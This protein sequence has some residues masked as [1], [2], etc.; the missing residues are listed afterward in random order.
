MSQFYK[1]CNKPFIHY[2]CT[3]CHGVIHKSCVNTKKIK[4]I[5]LLNGNR[6]MCCVSEHTNLSIQEEKNSLL[7]ETLNELT[8]ESELKSRQ[9]EKVKRDY[10]Q[11][12]SEASLR[13]DELN[14]LIMKNE[15]TIQRLERQ[16][17]EMESI[18]ASY[19]SK[20][21][22]HNSTQTNAIGNFPENRKIIKLISKETQTTRQ[23]VTIGTM[24]IPVQE[25]SVG[26]ASTRIDC[27]RV[28]EDN[29]FN[30]VLILSDDLGR[31]VNA[32][33]GNKLNDRYKI[34]C[35][36]KPGALYEQ[37]IEDLG[38]LAKDFTIEDH[39]VIIAGKNYFASKLKFPRCKSIWEQIK[40]CPTTNISFVGVP[41]L[42]YN[43]YNIFKFNEKL[44]AF[45]SRLNS[46]LPG[47]IDYMDV[48]DISSNAVGRIKHVLTKR[49]ANS[50]LNA[51]KK[52]NNLIFVDLNN[53]TT[54]DSSEIQD[55]SPSKSLQ[56]EMNEAMNGG[57]SC[58]GPDGVVSHLD[59]RSEVEVFSGGPFLYPRL[60]QLGLEKM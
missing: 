35:Y 5:R 24:T 18:I 13:E 46:C 14:K 55:N 44:E 59:C 3:Q 49:I 4:D 20:R 40:K 50:I 9:L 41:Y 12:L 52:Q 39:V 57:D 30:R 19:K 29:R 10:Q 31:N 23:S 27:D 42:N 48:T 15:E 37:V 47:R 26:E 51:C 25:E 33:L 28:N 7:E 17:V 54:M 11:F 58:G 36:Y 22:I 38:C 43:Q 45:T 16:I 2:V 32:L 21:F 1:C 6:V 8:T 56:I 53:E 60:S 34:Q